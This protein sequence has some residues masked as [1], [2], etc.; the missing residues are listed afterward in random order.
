[1]F[2]WGEWFRCFIRVSG[3]H[4]DAKADVVLMNHER[5]LL[6]VE[7][8]KVNLS[9]SL[10]VMAVPHATYFCEATFLICSSF[11]IPPLRLQNSLAN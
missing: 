9:S 8:D 4:V 7:E 2:G 5:H 11:Y 10:C 6:L 1:M 3:L